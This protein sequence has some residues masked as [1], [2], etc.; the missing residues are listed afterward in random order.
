MRYRS[1]SLDLPTA[2]S[3]MMIILMSGSSTVVNC[4][5]LEGRGGGVMEIIVDFM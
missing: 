2:V 5:S 1:R 3:P 4:C